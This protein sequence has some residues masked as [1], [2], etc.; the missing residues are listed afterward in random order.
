VKVTAE[1]FAQLFAT[2]DLMGRST[3]YVDG[4]LVD[5]AA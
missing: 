5:W 2:S 4:I 1:N 3:V